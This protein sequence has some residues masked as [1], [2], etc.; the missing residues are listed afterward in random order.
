LERLR[1]WRGKHFDEAVAGNDV[2]A[3]RGK[4]RVGFGP[5][6]L[7]RYRFEARVA[8]SIFEDRM[9]LEL[10]HDFDDNPGWVRRFHDEVVKVSPGLF[11]ATT[12]WR[13]RGRLIH[14]GYFALA[15]PPDR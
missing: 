15:F 12:H 13:L 10:D 14:L 8:R 4:N 9:I 3:G 1:I 6:E 5:Y 2:K 11:V 7:L